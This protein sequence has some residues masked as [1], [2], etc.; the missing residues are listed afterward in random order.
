MSQLCAYRGTVVVISGA[1][2]IQGVLPGLLSPRASR[3][4]DELIG[5]VI[6]NT[7]EG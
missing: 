3:S 6:A 1:A 4:F 5:G 7:V 2:A